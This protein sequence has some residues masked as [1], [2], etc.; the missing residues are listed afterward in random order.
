MNEEINLLLSSF[1]IY[2]IDPE[3]ANLSEDEKEWLDYFNKCLF[4][5]DERIEKASFDMMMLVLE[6]KEKMDTL[7]ELSNDEVMIRKNEIYKDLTEEEI[8]LIEKF[9]LSCINCMGIY[10]DEM[11]RERRLRDIGNK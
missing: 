8:D 9:G 11:K 1:S 2:T 10:S 3:Y 5:S 4:S 6:I 7:L